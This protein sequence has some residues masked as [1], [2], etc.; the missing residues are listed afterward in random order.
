MVRKLRDYRKKLVTVVADKRK[1]FQKGIYRT[2]RKN[3][4]SD[5]QHNSKR[6]EVIEKDCLIFMQ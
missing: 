5:Y 1:K 6:S 3:R 2:E 4:R